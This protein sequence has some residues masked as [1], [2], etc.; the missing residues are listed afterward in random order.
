MVIQ[1]ILFVIYNSFSYLASMFSSIAICPMASLILILIIVANILDLYLII[2]FDFYFSNTVILMFTLL[3]ML[4]IILFLIWLAN[5]TCDNY[6]WVSWL[7][8]LYLVW[9]IINTIILIFNP[10]K[11][12]EER[13]SLGL[14]SENGNGNGNGNGA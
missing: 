2:G 8:L 1:F 3:F 7:I 5:K 4:I 9:S 11:R 12:E 14:T 6:K 10:E 13:T